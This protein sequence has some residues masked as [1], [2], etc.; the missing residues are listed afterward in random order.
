MT[1][2]N[3]FCVAS[4]VC[5]LLLNCLDYHAEKLRLDADGSCNS[6]ASDDELDDDNVRLTDCLAF[7]L[8]VWLIFMVTITFYAAVFVFLQ[9]GVQFV[10][11]RYAISEK[12][13]SFMM[14]L[15]YTVSAL[16]CPV[17]GYFVD[18]TGRAVLW[19]LLSVGTLLMIQL[20]FA[21]WEDFSPSVGMVGMGLCYSICA[22]ALWPCISI[23]VQDK[24]LGMAYGLMTAFQ[25]LG[26]AV[27]PI[28]ISPLLPDA[29]RT[30][31]D[32]THQQFIDMYR[33]VLMVFAYLAAGATMST[34]LLLVA[35]AQQGG[36]LNASA[37]ELQQRDIARA[38]RSHAFSTV[39]ALYTHHVHSRNKYLSR[40]GIRP[41]GGPRLM[42]ETLLAP[43]CLPS[44]LAG[45]DG[46]GWGYDDAGSSRTYRTTQTYD[47]SFHNGSSRTY[48]QPSDNGLSAEGDGELREPLLGEGEWGEREGGRQRRGSWAQDWAGGDVLSASLASRGLLRVA[49]GGESLLDWALRQEGAGGQEV[50]GCG[51]G[52]RDA[53]GLRG[54]GRSH[55]G[56]SQSPDHLVFGGELQGPG[57]PPLLGRVRGDSLLSCAVSAGS[58]SVTVGSLTSLDRV[59]SLGVRSGAGGLG[60]DRGGGDEGDQWERGET[61]GN[62]T[63]ARLASR[64]TGGSSETSE[65]YMTASEGVSSEEPGE[66]GAGQEIP[67]DHN[68]PLS[69]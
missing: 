2:G 55:R 3:L 30:A 60:G 43:G 35:D 28:V 45:R 69:S 22:S 5:C 1:V 58:G 51:P 9:N 37:A 18:K 36:W 24:R 63:E 38:R 31:H 61:I 56:R 13:S 23:V 21:L 33:D 4:L 40:L 39:P 49:D 47:S 10:H 66:L 52:S 7:P 64:Q 6:V 50:E 11:Q 65:G 16:A 53:A 17:F 27:F 25:N 62:T 20:S 48:R 54:D 19:I 32:T 26:M 59:D 12:N 46:G 15:P 68:P 14:S 41:L 34:V 57:I 42:S 8:T 29:D 44:G 67:V